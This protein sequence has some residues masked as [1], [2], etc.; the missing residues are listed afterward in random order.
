VFCVQEGEGEEMFTE[1]VGY[2][3][4]DES[5]PSSSGATSAPKS[6]RGEELEAVSGN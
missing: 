2:R 6:S 5:S 4:G 3:L 1:C